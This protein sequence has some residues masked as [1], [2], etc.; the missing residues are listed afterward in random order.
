MS[1]AKIILRTAIAVRQHA[2]IR[3]SF[4]TN[5][6]CRGAIKTCRHM[7]W[8][9]FDVW[10]IRRELNEYEHFSTTSVSLHTVHN[11]TLLAPRQIDIKT[12]LF[13]ALF[14]TYGSCRAR[15][16]CCCRSWRS[17]TPG[18]PRAPSRT[19]GHPPRT[20]ARPPGDTTACRTTPQS[21]VCGAPLCTQNIVIRASAVDYI[22]ELAIQY[23]LETE[24]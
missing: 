5:D 8:R 20:S 14:S 19:A 1:Y 9:S 10:R 18:R 3:F 17:T 13:Y 16:R 24:L 23:I 22:P 12:E 6:V 7:R 4:H 11:Q 15:V 2:E 21:T